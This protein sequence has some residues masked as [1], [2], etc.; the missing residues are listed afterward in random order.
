M[1][2]PTGWPAPDEEDQLL[3][4]LNTDTPTAQGGFAELYFPLLVQFLARKIPRVAADLREEAAGQAVLDFLRPRVGSTRRGG[5]A[6]TCA[7][8]P[9]TTC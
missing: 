5:S 7:W 9:G 4:Q 1:N 3:T 2:P 8:R 6:R